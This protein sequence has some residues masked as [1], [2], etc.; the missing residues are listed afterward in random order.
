MMRPSSA[1]AT[2]LAAPALGQLLQQGEVRLRV[3]L[4]HH[5][6]QLR[7]EARVGPYAV[8]QLEGAGA[9]HARAANGRRVQA[10]DRRAAR[11]FPSSTWS[12]ASAATPPRP[13]AC[14]TAA[15]W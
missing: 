1:D 11:S 7:V 10:R 6:R 14:S 12:R 3:G 13:W 4:H 8:L 2:S 5:E 9:D 15:W